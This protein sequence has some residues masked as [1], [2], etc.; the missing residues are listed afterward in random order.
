MVSA[1]LR[2][3]GGKPPPSFLLRH[4]TLTSAGGRV[5][6]V[7]PRVNTGINPAESEIA[8]ITGWS[9]VTIAEDLKASKAVQD[10]TETVQKRTAPDPDREAA[11]AELAAI[12][13]KRATLAE[14]V[15]HLAGKLKDAKEGIGTGGLAL[16]VALRRLR[17]AYNIHS[18]PPPLALGPPCEASRLKIRAVAATADLDLDRHRFHPQCWPKLDPSKIKLVMNHDL[19][20]EVGTIDTIDIDAMGRMT[21]VATVTDPIAMRLP[22]LSISACV[23]QFAIRNAESMTFVGEVLRVS[24]INE[25]T[26]TQTPSNRRCTV[27]ERWIPTPYELSSEALMAK[28][29]AFQATVAALQASSV[30]ARAA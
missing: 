22:G 7:E 6:V 11:L 2:A 14:D 15:Q 25:I 10:R 5:H 1:A 21:I 20:K 18:D 30:F 8:E 13:G 12:A 19:T 4:L 17:Q 28:V 23:E 27:V 9:H 26:L 16:T 24:S 29:K 3:F